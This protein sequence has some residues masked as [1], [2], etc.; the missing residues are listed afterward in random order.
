MITFVVLLNTQCSK[1]NWDLQYLS[2]KVMLKSKWV[3]L[4]LDIDL[5]TLIILQ[6]EFSFIFLKFTIYLRLLLENFVENH[7]FNVI[8]SYFKQF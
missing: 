2:L 8:S 4:N 7:Q 5:M 1:P 3:S 6:L